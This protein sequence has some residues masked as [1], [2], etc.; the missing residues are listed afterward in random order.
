MTTGTLPRDDAEDAYSSLGYQLPG[1]PGSACKARALVAG[2]LCGLSPDV[3]L[4]AQLLASE[5]VANA[6]VHAMTR[7]QLDIAISGSTVLI[8]VGDNSAAIPQQQQAF[9]SPDAVSGRGLALVDRLSSAFG[10][11]RIDEGKRVWFE[12]PLH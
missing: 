2:V 4:L 9:G 1:V 3:V 5:L 10:W 11:D 6:V 8:S 7:V 12:L